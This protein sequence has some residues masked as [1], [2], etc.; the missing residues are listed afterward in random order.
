MSVAPMPAGQPGTRDT[1]GSTLPSAII[2]GV[3]P[4][5]ARPSATGPTGSIVRDYSDYSGSYTG[6]S[7]NGYRFLR[8]ALTCD[9]DGLLSG[10]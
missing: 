8:F 5:R 2:S 3:V 7:L 10:S 4:R 1:S 9:A 6:Q